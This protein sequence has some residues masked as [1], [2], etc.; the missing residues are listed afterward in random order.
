MRLFAVRDGRL[1][2]YHGILY[3]FAVYL[4]EARLTVHG[5]F[6]LPVY[7]WIFPLSLIQTFHFVDYFGMLLSN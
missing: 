3:A 1:F 2:M 4:I 7:F 6:L 5:L